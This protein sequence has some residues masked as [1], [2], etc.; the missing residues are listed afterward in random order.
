MK[1]DTSKL[2]YTWKPTF[3]YEWIGGRFGEPKERPTPQNSVFC[4]IVS[5]N[6][7]NSNIEK[8][9]YVYGWIERWNWVKED[10]GLPEA[11]INWVDR[12]KKKIYTRP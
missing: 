8:F 5:P 9:P 2:I 12:Y 4:V 1:G 11:P 6:I 7:R 3:D 10:K